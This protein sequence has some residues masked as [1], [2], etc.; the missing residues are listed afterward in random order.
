MIARFTFVVVFLN[1]FASFLFDRRNVLRLHRK[2]ADGRVAIHSTSG[3]ADVRALPFSIRLGGFALAHCP[4]SSDP[5]SC[6]DRIM[7]RISNRAHPR[8]VFVGGILSMG[9]CQFFRTSCSPSRRNA[10]LSIGHS[11][12][13]HGVACAKCLLLIVKLIL[14]FVN[15]GAQFVSLDHQLGRLRATAGVV[16]YLLFFVTFPSRDETGRGGSP[17]VSVMRGRGVSP[18]RTRIFNS[19]PVRS[20]DKHAVPV[21]AFSSR[22]LQGLRGSSGVKNLGSSRFLVDLLIVPS[23]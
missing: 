1:T 3:G 6:R 19:L 18:T 10:V 22:V 21:G 20:G 7:M 5:S 4:N 15:G 8:Q 17:V 2:R 13:K 11:I 9:N 16:T 14:Y 12:T 23:M